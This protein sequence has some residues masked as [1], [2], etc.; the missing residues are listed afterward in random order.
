MIAGTAERLIVNASWQLI[1]G[2]AGGYLSDGSEKL[3]A[4][5][6]EGRNIRRNPEVDPKVKPEDAIADEGWKLS[7]KARPEGW[8]PMK[9]GS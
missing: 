6:T 3:I 1:D 5:R 9:V 7:S 2:T 4:G 8:Q